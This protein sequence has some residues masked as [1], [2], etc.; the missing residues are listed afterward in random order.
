VPFKIRNLEIIPFENK[1]L[2]KDPLG[3][4]KEMILN[5]ESFLLF[6]M[7]DGEEK[8][9]DI[10]SKFLRNTGIILSDFEII[11]FINEMDKN[12]IF[13]NENFLKKIEEEKIKM[14][15]ISFKEIKFSFDFEKIKKEIEKNE[16]KSSDIKGMMVP[17]IDINVAFDTYLKSY[18]YLKNL[19]KKIF[20]ILGVPHFYS[21]NVFSVFPKNY[22]FLDKIIEVKEEIIKNFKNKFEFDIFKD[23]IAFK[24]EHS[25]EFP[26][27]FLSLIKENFYIVPSLV[28]KSE[29]ENLKKIANVIFESLNLFKEDIFLISSVDLSHVGKKFGDENSFD[30]TEIDLKYIEYLKNFENENAFDFIEKNKN[31]TKIDG[32]YTNFLFIELLKLLGAK[33]GE[34]VDYK[35]YYESFTDSI[36]SYATLIFE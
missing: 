32:V 27:I 22:K 16:F 10:K 11:N 29:K 20:L 1:F 19:D 31:F 7:I 15:E 17:H 12:C 3:I 18:S 33:K 36:V 28:S 9:E 30:T 5:R 8:I 34:I 21:E 25:V 35:K 6:S 13:L 23:I 24:N 4:S 26:I 14:M 2:I